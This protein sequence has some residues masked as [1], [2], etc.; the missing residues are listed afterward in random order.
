MGVKSAPCD[1]EPR[2][3]LSQAHRK[4]N[5]GGSSS[6]KS[7]TQQQQHNKGKGHDS[8]IAG[9]QR[10]RVSCNAFNNKNKCCSVSPRGTTKEGTLLQRGHWH[11][12]PTSLYLSLTQT[13]VMLV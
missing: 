12:A 13:L 4:Q 10:Q 3:F 5:G 9:Q 6:L 1:S 2:S 8:L 7:V 11:T